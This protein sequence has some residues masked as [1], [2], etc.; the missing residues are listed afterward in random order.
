MNEKSTESD[1][2]HLVG[3]ILNGDQ[4]AETEMVQSYQHSLIYLLRRRCQDTDTADDIAQETWR[5]VIEKIR[6][7]DLRDPKKLAA[8][9][10]QTGKNQLLMRYRR[11][12]QH[13]DGDDLDNLP[14]QYP[15][16]GTN[17]ENHERKRLVGQV[18]SQL[19]AARDR[20]ILLR[21]YLAEEDKERICEELGVSSLHFN[22]IL[23]R[24]RQRFGELWR[25]H[26]DGETHL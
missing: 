24:A 21:F 20:E 22:R 25:K 18:L 6:A 3:R 26:N 1:A 10:L 12:R 14:S 9:I 5:V 16:P 2:Q 17:L 15:T 4:Y 8:F 11:S 13:T 7:G 23:F 19:T